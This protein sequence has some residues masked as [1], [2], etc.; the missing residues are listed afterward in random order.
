M[1][2]DVDRERDAIIAVIEAETV[3]FFSRDFD[4][5]AHC[6]LQDEGARRLGMLV[7]GQIGYHEGW[8]AS[9]TIVARIMEQFPEP[10]PE[11]PRLMRRENFNLHI[12]GDM[13]WASFDQYG[14]DTGD[15]FDSRGLSHQVRVLQKLDGAWKIAFAGHGETSVDYFAFPVIRV[16]RDA[17]IL[18]MNDAARQSL[19]DHPALVRSGGHLRARHREGD[20]RLRAALI[21]VDS[22]SPMEI[23][24]SVSSPL[25]KPRTI[26][27][28]LASDAAKVSSICW[29]SS[30][31]GMLVVS[32]NDKDSEAKRLA[33]AQSVFR[34]SPAQ[35]RLAA[36]IIDGQDLSMAA[37]KLNISA[38]TARTH[39]Q[40]MFDKTGVRAQAALVRVLLSVELPSP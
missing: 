7:G 3:A 19:P 18:W 5:W 12:A 28:I 35:M 38:T 11:A 6:W 23:R 26:P 4:L 36:L 39:L 29:V 21:Q 22:L 10:N 27:V 15:P 8:S 31:D 20:K 17:S 33:A 37:R 13:A 32:F 34:L 9:A 24:M 30:Q 16:D 40:R 25:E 1:N 14:P 2:E